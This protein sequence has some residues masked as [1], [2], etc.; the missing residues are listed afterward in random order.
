[1]ESEKDESKEEVRQPTWIMP[2]PMRD[3]TDYWTKFLL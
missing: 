3:L 1:M 2:S